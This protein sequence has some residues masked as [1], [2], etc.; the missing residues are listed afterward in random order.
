MCV[1]ACELILRVNHHIN[2]AEN[3]EKSSKE[4]ECPLIRG[5]LPFIDSQLVVTTLE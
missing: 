4:N 3:T 1:E 5:S 2:S